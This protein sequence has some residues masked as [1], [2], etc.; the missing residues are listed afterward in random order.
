MSA[1]LHAVIGEQHLEIKDLKA[2]YRQ[3][4]HV[5]A[6][7]VSGEMERS[8]LLVNLT[9]ESC[10]WSPAGESPGMPCTINGL[11]QCVVAPPDPKDEQIAV[12]T[13]Q[14]E[15]LKAA[16]LALREAKERAENLH[17]EA[18]ALKDGP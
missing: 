8:R 9:D 13:L 1:A 3:L 6:Q 2:R 11:P 14:I 17:E 10:L 15:G 7:V 5:L 16:N 18:D 4:L 12:L